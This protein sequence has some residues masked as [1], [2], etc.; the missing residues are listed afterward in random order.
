MNILILNWKDL[1]HPQVGG[2][3]IIVYELAK[4]FVRDGHKVTWFCRKYI[5][6]KDE[7]EYDGINVVR[8]GNLITT[9]FYAP[10]YYWGLKDKP[11]VIIDMSNTIYWQTPLWAWRSKKVAYLNQLGQ[12]VFDYEYPKILAFIGKLIE[13]IQ[14]FTYR[15][16]K[17][18]VYSNSTKNDLV[19]MGA[20]EKNIKTFR[21]GIDH[22]RYIPGK[23]SK[24]P[25]LL[26]VSRLV[27]MKR[28]DLA[29]KAMKH[30]V[31]KIPEA[32][33]LIVGYGYDRKRLELLRDYLDLQENVIFH[34]ENV[35]FFEKNVK[36]E[37][38]NLMQKAWA[39]VFPSV[40]EGWGMT[41]TECAACGTPAI[42]T[43]VT[44]L[45]DSVIKDETGLIVSNDPS[46]EELAKAMIKILKDEKLR[47]KLSKNAIKWAKEFT[48]ENSYMEFGSILN[49]IVDAEI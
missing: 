40:K 49:K 23:K 37:K 10:F 19:S 29:I 13:R 32:K 33:L 8:R 25:L 34:H 46:E 3:E 12:E 41:V 30:V 4:R 9:Y 42:V 17:Y 18:V 44:G 31:R 2:A 36:D 27:K 15:G 5:Y 22:K 21:L 45:R 7:E 1:K 11:D 6:S 24:T 28:N 35:L 16:M 48:W 47:N 38:V 26:C 43:D 14:Y 20:K 39:L